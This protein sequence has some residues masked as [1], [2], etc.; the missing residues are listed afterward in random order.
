M[1]LFLENPVQDGYAVLVFSKL[2][3]F[4]TTQEY[5]IV[6]VEHPLTEWICP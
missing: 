6:T 1:L 4:E 5:D 2:E 3:A